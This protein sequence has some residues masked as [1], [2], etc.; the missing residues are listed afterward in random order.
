[1]HEGMSNYQLLLRKLDEFIRKHYQYHMIRGALFWLALFLA[2]GLAF[3]VVEFY[4]HFDKGVRTGLFY[5]FLGLNGAG[6]FYWIGMPLL[7]LLKLGKGLSHQQAAR[8]IGRHFPEVKDKLL[9]TLELY[10]M[11]AQQGADQRLIEASVNQRIE[12]LKPIPFARAIDLRDTK[13]Y[14][15]YAVTPL[16][17]LLI[18][19]FISPRMVLDSTERLLNHRTYYE[20]QAPFEFQLVN[21]SL[22]AIQEKSYTVELKT[23]GRTLPEDV[24]VHIGDSRY[25]MDKQ[26]VNKHRYTIRNLRN[27]FEMQ[28]EGNG[29]YSRPYEVDVLPQPRLR[30][31]QVK[32]DYPDY[33]GK[34]DQVRQNVGD[35][36]VP[37]GTKVEWQFRTR[38]TSQV[39][40]AFRDT[41]R[42]PD[43]SGEDQFT[44]AKRF[45]QSQPYRVKLANQHMK[46]PDSIQHFL[47][48][49]P[50]AYP[51]IKVEQREDSLS[52]KRQFFSGE[53]SDDY[54]LSALAFHYKYT[55][56][57]DSAK[58]NQGLQTQQL[59]IKPGQSL[60][61]FFHTFNLN[62]LDIEAGDE[63][64]YYF[65]VWDNDAVNGRKSSRS[66]QFTFQAPTDEALEEQMEK[67]Q[68][69]VQNELADA[70][71]K[72]KKLQQQ[73]NK[74]RQKLLNKDKLSWEDKQ[75]VK[76][77]LQQY[78]SLRQQV[79]QLQQQYRQ[80][81]RRQDE[82]N[83]L[84]KEM[85]QQYERM[86]EIMKNSASKKLQ[87]ELDELEQMLDKSDKQ[88]IQKQMEKL[89]RK[90]NS[91]Q[92]R[93]ER[94]LELYKQLALEQKMRSTA[95]ELDELSEKQKKLSQETKGK[96]AEKA[97]EQQKK[98]GDDQ[99]EKADQKGEEQG[100]KASDKQKASDQ[101]DRKN[102]DKAKPKDQKDQ[103]SKSDAKDPSKKQDG[104]SPKEQQKSLKQEFEGVKKDL[105][106]I[107]KLKQKLD[108]S[109]DMQELKQQSQE[110]QKLMQQSLQKLRQQNQQGASQKQ[111][112][113][114]EK[115]KS[116][117]QKMRQ[118]MQQMSQQSIRLNYKKVRQILENLIHF[119]KE[120]ETLIHKFNNINNYNPQ[121]VKNAAKQ[122]RLKAQTE[123][124]E[125]SLQAL[126]QKVM[127]IKTTVNREIEDINYYMKKVRQYISDRRIGKI[128]SSQQYIMTAAN[129][130]AVMLSE[131]MGQMQQQMASQM[132]GG[133]MCQKPKPGQMGKK[134]GKSLKQIR[135][136]QQKLGKQL[137]DLKK[138]KQGSRQG[139]G[140]KELAR[141]QKLQQQLRQRIREMRK[142]K[143]MEGEQ[144][145]KSELKQV[146]ELM[147]KQERDIINNNVTGE[148]MQ[149]QQQIN[150]K[151][152]E[153]QNAERTQ[154]RD[155]ERKSKTAEELFRQNPPALEEYREERK[156]QIELLQT[157]PP[158]LRGYYRMKVQEYFKAIQ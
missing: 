15:K 123:M 154:G 109:G 99:Q 115:M 24:Y 146:E 82:Y 120:Q 10:Q 63:L 53:A 148:T 68:E 158:K 56:S 116:M 16:V 106:D 149:R 155:K 2:S 43:P 118:Q 92:S 152:L 32:L 141:L 93:L 9:N 36:D 77:T 133:Q 83:Q 67:T 121:F 39:T 127:Q 117:S 74:A 147:E 38:N 110:I 58:V 81:L 17:I 48:V 14:A 112:K 18:I 95:K 55:S 72:A 19:S 142:K 90:N 151:M 144:S 157:V 132:K 79:R 119:S 139:A 31:Y 69:E 130:L 143:D 22:K 25:R 137:Q 129:N 101:S 124:I 128:R 60:K 113:A 126:S 105:Q 29:F 131:L 108:K 122:T 42:K 104:S 85:K 138:G 46:S 96:D 45:Y 35:L 1:M 150:V 153:A 136:M 73:L 75:F 28:F 23:E 50:D 61:Q 89:R 12:A 66:R 70:S 33:T 40:L 37:E 87:E 86:N 80:N 6:L 125:D 57:S 134:S 91:T 94:S 107:G 11:G 4:G 44:V 47:S 140:S 84:S 100:E 88:A 135:Q 145:G 64:T 76:E 26:A 49:V 59:A 27:G 111:Q 98:A 20:E 51:K 30:A 103:K 13:R 78:R 65:E 102:E 62:K 34:A 114:G 54:G 71:K 41:I 52:R 156:Q 21:D 7:K 3:A 8:I 5:L 97:G